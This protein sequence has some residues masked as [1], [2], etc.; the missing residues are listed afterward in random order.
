M[1]KELQTQNI[2][3]RRRW[4]IHSTHIKMIQVDRVGW[5]LQVTRV[6]RVVIVAM[7][8]SKNEKPM[9][10]LSVPLH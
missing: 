7:F 8:Y 9:T 6:V 3:I 5:G 2:K 10:W 4:A 1:K